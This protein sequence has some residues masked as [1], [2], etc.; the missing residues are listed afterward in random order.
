MNNKLIRLSERRE[1]LVAQTAAQRRILAKSIEPW[2]TPLARVDRG[3]AALHYLRNHPV[4]IVGGI[5]LLA[6]FRPNRVG[7]WL[8]LGWVTW[9]LSRKLLVK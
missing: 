6:A 4:W 7:K 1:R 8:Q 5:S 3:L 2:R 9:Q